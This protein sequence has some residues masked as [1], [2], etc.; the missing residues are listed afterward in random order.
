MPLRT[1]LFVDDERITLS[2]LQRLFR[3]EPYRAL[4]AA[5]GSQALEVLE[6]E[7]VDVVVTDMMMPEMD[8]LTLLDWVQAEYPDSIRVIMSAVNDTDSLLEAINRGSV[9]RYIVK[10]WNAED[11]K[12]TV[13]QAVEFF[14]IQSERNRLLADLES[15][16]HLLRARIQQRTDQLMDLYNQAEIGKYASHIVHNLNSPLQAIFG[17]LEL[18]RMAVNR[19]PPDKRDVLALLDRIDQRADHLAQI[20]R[21]ILLHAR[22]DALHHHDRLDL[23]AILEDEVAFFELDANFKKGIQRRLNLDTALPPIMG[24]AAQIKQIIH[25]LVSNA[26][27]AMDASKEKVLTVATA[28]EADWAEI[29]IGDTGEGIAPEH[30]QKIFSPNFT[31]KPPGKGTGLGLASVR[32]MANAYGGEVLVRSALGRGTTVT[33]RLPAVIDPA[34]GALT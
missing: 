27:D 30:L 22:D 10:P 2:A 24:N 26:V 6:S 3:A 4:F 12:I 11:F 34:V 15:A 21:T 18:C 17:A 28:T 23:N 7:P 32:T 31:T 1:V 9:Y 33:V 8:G 14:E 29:I 5:S 13:R 25:N 16:N 20:V 19:E